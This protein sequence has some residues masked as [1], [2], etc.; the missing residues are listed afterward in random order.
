[1]I[2]KNYFLFQQRQKLAFKVTL[3][4]VEPCSLIYN[5]AKCLSTVKR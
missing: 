3:E 4:M 2:A 5:Q 1:M